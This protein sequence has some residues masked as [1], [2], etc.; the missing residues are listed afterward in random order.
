MVAIISRRLARGRKIDETELTTGVIRPSNQILRRLQRISYLVHL[1][2]RASLDVVA[3][4]S[5][6]QTE[7]QTWGTGVVVARDRPVAP[8]KVQYRNQ[9]QGNTYLSRFVAS[10][11][12]VP[13]C[14]PLIG[15]FLCDCNY[16]VS[17][18]G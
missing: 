3:P 6:I 17:V 14:S 13:D 2:A 1:V 15:S 8:R 11:S 4:L 18:S 16:S 9:L 10:S 12:V 7:F 5:D